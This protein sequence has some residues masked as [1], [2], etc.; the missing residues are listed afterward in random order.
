MPHIATII[1]SVDVA[2][3]PDGP[4]ARRVVVSSRQGRLALARLLGTDVRLGDAIS[5]DHEVWK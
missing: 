3:A 4:F 2:L 1:P 5:S